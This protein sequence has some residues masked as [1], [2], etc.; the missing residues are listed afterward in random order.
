MLGIEIQPTLP[1]TDD[2]DGPWVKLRL[3]CGTGR[4][5]YGEM[6]LDSEVPGSV[7]LCRRDVQGNDASPLFRKCP[8]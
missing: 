4:K 7:D 2:I 6:F 5:V 8:R 3:F 1:A